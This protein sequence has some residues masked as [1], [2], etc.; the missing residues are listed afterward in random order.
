MTDKKTLGDIPSKMIAVDPETGET[1]KEFGTID[2]PLVELI[3][4]NPKKIYSMQYIF[5]VDWELENGDDI[6]LDE[7]EM[8]CLDATGMI[9]MFS[10]CRDGYTQGEIKATINGKTYIAFWHVSDF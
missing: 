9:E 1:I 6:K 2:V 10:K 8:E 4:E 5:D 7:F 3:P